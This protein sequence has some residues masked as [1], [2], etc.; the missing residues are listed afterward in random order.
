MNM[1]PIIDI[2]KN[3]VTASYVQ[4]LIYLL[5]LIVLFIQARI[6]IRQ[7][8]HQESAV[9]LQTEAL[10]QSEYMR[11]QI[12][13]TETLRLLASNGSHARIYDDLA[14]AGSAFKGWKEYTADQKQTYAYLEMVYEVLERVFVISKDGWI[15]E[16]EWSQWEKWVDDVISNPLF[17]HV[18]DDNLGMF[19]PRFE[20][21]IKNRISK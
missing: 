20:Q 21:Y 16:S 8:R 14:K 7:T 13:F 11:C 18:C 5:T 2:L 3:P 12:D 17:A 15:P 19:D 1:Q 6:L 4:A 10:R 9:R